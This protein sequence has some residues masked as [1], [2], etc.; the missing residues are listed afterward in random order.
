[1]KSPADS[2]PPAF[3]PNAR[4]LGFGF[5][6]LPKTGGRPDMPQIERMVDLFLANGFS[7][8][9]TAYN[10]EGSEDALRHAL[11]ERHPRDSWLLADKMCAWQEKSREK[12]LEQFDISLA[13]TG[14]GYFDF[15]LLHALG[16]SRTQAFEAWDIWDFCRKKMDEGL[17]RNFGFSFHGTPEELDEILTRHPE[18][19]FVQLQINY[20]DWE[21]IEVRARECYETAT[22]H[23][24]PIIV[25]EP[26]RGGM[27]ANGLPGGARALFQ[28]A[29]RGGSLSPAAFAL[30]FA[31]ALPGVRVVLS[32][33]SDLAQM[34]ENIKIFKGEIERTAGEKALEGRLRELFAAIE[35]VPCTGCGYCENV[36]PQNVGIR[37]VMDAINY[38][39]TWQDRQK[40]REWLE[41]MLAPGGKGE[42]RSSPD[43][44]V[45]CGECEKACP[46][47]IEIRKMIENLRERL[48]V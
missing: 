35:R 31:A 5:M 16:H 36:C 24:K 12:A 14:A 23:G 2:R 13:R 43:N 18:A 33:M 48:S 34:E 38:D 45:G 30:R 44:C 9:D 15:Y 41:V 32:G 42:H 27:L 6:R 7:Y 8:F 26:V 17:I 10:Y 22:A 40:T 3:P 28:E 4:K 19:Q 1:M 46:Q 25:M 20:A 39:R 29:K 11:A 47:G 21:D 37:C